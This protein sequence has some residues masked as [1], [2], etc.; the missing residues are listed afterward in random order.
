MGKGRKRLYGLEYSGSGPAYIED[1][2]Q[3]LKI[4]GIL[5][6]GMG[7]NLLLLAPNA[8]LTGD[9]ET[10]LGC[11]ER[12]IHIAAPDLATWCEI[13]R[14]TD[15]PLVYE[16]D[17]TGTIKAIHRKQEF[18]ISGAV[19]QQ[20]WVRDEFRCLFCGKKM[21]D[22]QLTVDHFI[23]LEAG[24][25]NDETNYVSACR[26]CNKRKGKLAPQ[27][28]CARHGLDYDGLCLYLAG[29]CSLSFVLHLK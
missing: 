28:Y 25:A 14:R 17:E 1:A 8:N 21:G 7:Q 24:G 2:G 3:I 20:I 6:Q 5:F 9:I 10:C 4:S 23:P 26:Q 15:D 12:E 18:A 11:C 13:L 22:V 29:R 19:Q 27:V 16:Q